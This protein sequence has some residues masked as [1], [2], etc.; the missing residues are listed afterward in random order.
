MILH[1]PP[2][3]EL[4]EVLDEIDRVLELPFWLEERT[5]RMPTDAE[6]LSWRFVG[7]VLRW[8]GEGVEV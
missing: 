4:S 5:G 1:H 8:A 7:D 2:S 6:L 3:T